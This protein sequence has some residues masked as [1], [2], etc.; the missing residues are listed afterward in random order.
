[1]V[2]RPGQV[3]EILV[4]LTLP[5]QLAGRWCYNRAMTKTYVPEDHVIHAGALLSIP[6]AEKYLRPGTYQVRGR[7]KT[8]PVTDLVLTVLPGASRLRPPR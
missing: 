6:E 8:G 1:M 7:M 4:F 3:F 5:E 2:P